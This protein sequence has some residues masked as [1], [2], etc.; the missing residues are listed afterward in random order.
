MPFT[1]RHFE[2][3]KRARMD[4]IEHAKFD[5]VEPSP[6]YQKEEGKFVPELKFALLSM[7]SGQMKITGLPI[8]LR[9]Y[10]S[11]SIQERVATISK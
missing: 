11:E 6:V 7:S 8:Y 1:L 3:E 9:L 5:L 2:D 4:V 10:Q